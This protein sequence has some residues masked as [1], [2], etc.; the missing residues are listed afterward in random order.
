MRLPNG[1]HA[2]IAPAKL[3]GY[4]LSE[5]HPAGQSKAKFFRAAGFDQTT[6]PVLQDGLLLIA[7]ECEV[8]SVLLTSWHEIHYRWFIV[9]PR[10]Q[11]SANPHHLDY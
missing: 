7:K 8:P 3:A 10:R 5:T 6:L 4:L 1:D 2:F 9:D 11:R